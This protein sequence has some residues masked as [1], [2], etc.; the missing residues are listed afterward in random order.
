MT[1]DTTRDERAGLSDGGDGE[2]F[3]RRPF[4]FTLRTLFLFTTL[5]AVYCSITCSVGYEEATGVMLALLLAL[6]AVRWRGRGIF[7]AIRVLLAL[8]AIGI[9]WMVA[10]DRSWV[11]EVCSDCL[12]DRDILQYRLFRMPVHE[13]VVGEHS[14]DNCRIALDLGM[15]CQHRFQRVLMTRYWGLFLPADPSFRGTVRL[16]GNEWYDD[17]MA[18]IVRAKGRETPGLAEEFH[19]KVIVEHDWNYSWA[20]FD[21]VIRRKESGNQRQTQTTL[22]ETPSVSPPQ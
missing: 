21:D 17:C 13:E 1:G 4:Q 18:E 11:R 2:R 3:A 9:F 14:I 22:P 10:V 5:V 15:P 16:A 7:T 12:L 8:A 6:I 20:F 19:Q